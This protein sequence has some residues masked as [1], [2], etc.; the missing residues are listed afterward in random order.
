MTGK[1]LRKQNFRDNKGISK[2]IRLNI[3]AVIIFIFGGIIIFRLFSLQILNHDFYSAMAAGQHEIS[4]SLLPE[5]GKILIQ[6]IGDSS[7]LYPLATNQSLY[8]VYVEPNKVENSEELSEKL[9]DIFFTRSEIEIKEGDTPEILEA[10]YKEEREKVFQEILS[11]V[12]K[13]NDPYEPLR[14]GVSENTV[15]SIKALNVSGIG[16]IKE[17]ARFYPEKNIGSHFLGFLGTKNDEKIGQYGLEGYFETELAGKKGYIESEKDVAGRWIP[18][19]GR[20][21]EKAENGTDLVL[22]IDRNIQ[23][24]ACEKLREAVAKHQADGGSVIIMDPKTGAIWAMC[25]HPDF[26]PNDYSKISD[27]NI[28][29][30][31]AIFYQYEPG[32]IFKAITIA[33]ALDLDKITPT[34]TY[35]DEGFLKI[36][37]YTIRNSD[38]K[39]HG[40]QTMTQVLDESLNTGVVFAL[41]KMGIEAFRKYV[42]DFGFGVMTGI[43]LNYEASGNV[44]SLE[45]KGE[46]WGATAS[47]GQGISVTPIQMV[48]AFGALANNGKLMK[49]YIIDRMEKNT[50]EI[51]NT[52]PKVVQQ[53]ISGRA[54]TLLGGMLVSVVE[55]GHGKRAGV[56]GYYVAGKTGTAQVPKKDGVGYEQDVT[57]G[58]FI[59]FAPVED[60]KFVMLT[61]IDH[62]R[63]VIWAESSAAPLFGEIAQYVLN[64][65]R[66]PPNRK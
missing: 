17:S 35:N 41:N 61:K 32:S 54:A 49:P 39:A 1:Y 12:G 57:I 19:S 23:F 50:G 15:S 45:N 8:Q 63:D 55:N 33:A 65:L 18:I 42:N 58:S 14:K 38:L 9:T 11:K 10:K 6:E 48:S 21:W 62:P 4:E 64:Y 5:R 53:V 13:G 2:N 31:P 51:I 59:G 34:T 52:S 36:G 28:F 20:S 30:N 29:N 56:S 60:P 46:I 40:I 3:L 7:T 16:F 26:D 27:I 43:E 24:F 66:V 37:G 47:F 22:T 44:K 25:S